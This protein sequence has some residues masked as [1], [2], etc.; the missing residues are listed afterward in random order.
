[1]IAPGFPQVSDPCPGNGVSAG[2]GGVPSDAPAVDRCHPAAWKVGTGPHINAFGLG[3]YGRT[4]SNVWTYPGTNSFHAGRGDE[5][6][7]HPTVKPIALVADAIC[8]C[9]TKGDTVL[10]VFLGSGTTIMAAEKVGRCG[11]GI[12][13]DPAYVDVSVRRWQKYTKADAMLLGNGRTFEDIGAER[14]AREGADWDGVSGLEPRAA[15][16]D[17]KSRYRLARHGAPGGTEDGK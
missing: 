16:D 5:L 14:L 6:V 7:M 11:F 17:P 13:C 3:Q 2:I 10:D 15:P 8:D 4:R 12:K 9:S 1:M